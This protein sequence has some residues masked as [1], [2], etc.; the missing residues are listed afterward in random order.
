MAQFVSDGRK[1][2]SVRALRGWQ[3][4]DDEL[5]QMFV[6]LRIGVRNILPLESQDELC[7]LVL[8]E[9]L[10]QGEEGSVD[11]E[12]ISNVRGIPDNTEKV[13][14]FGDQDDGVDLSLLRTVLY[15]ER[16]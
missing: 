11:F 14:Y 15:E 5:R 1:D 13:Q 3:S 4:Y 8:Q 10:C 16:S 2:E 12:S 7:F 6:I 9:L